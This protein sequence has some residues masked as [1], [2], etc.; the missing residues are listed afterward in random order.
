[1]PAPLLDEIQ[2]IGKEEE[3]EEDVYDEP[4][5]PLRSGMRFYFYKTL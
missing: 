2:H 5:Q 4:E 3:V 1:M